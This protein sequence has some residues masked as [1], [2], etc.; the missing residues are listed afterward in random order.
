[1]KIKQTLVTLSLTVSLLFVGA[2]VGSVAH[3]L[4]GDTGGDSA[5]SS[6]SSGNQ[7]TS[8][9]NN[10]TSQT[11]GTS[12]TTTDKQCGGVNTSIIECDGDDKEAK[13]LEDTGLWGL[14]ILSINIMTAG[15]GVLAVGGIV[16]GSILYTTAGGSPEQV[17][18]AITIIRNVV[19]GIVMY[20]MMFGFLNYIIPG[21]IFNSK[22]T[23]NSTSS[24][25]TQPAGSSTTPL[26]GAS[27]GPRS[28][29]STVPTAGGNH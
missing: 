1:M 10:S 24:T 5:T 13:N 2:F 22:S 23:N 9:T 28:G 7:S 6:S 21:G 12:T 8:T 20:L 15:V 17:K 3:A 18:Q 29:A 11:T 19:I 27:T 26:S 25:P 14:L 4:P 16:W